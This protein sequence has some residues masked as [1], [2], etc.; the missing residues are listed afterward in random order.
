VGQ[1][2]A[3]CTL[4]EDKQ[5]KDFTKGLDPDFKFGLQALYEYVK[6]SRPNTTYI[7]LSEEDENGQ[8]SK[9]TGIA[10]IRT[11]IT[12]LFNVAESSGKVMSISEKAYFNMIN[13]VIGIGEAP[14]SEFCILEA[15][16]ERDHGTLTIEFFGKA[17]T[18]DFD[19]DE[20]LS[21]SDDSSFG[22]G[23]GY[24]EDGSD[25][26]D[27]QEQSNAEFERLQM[28]YADLGEPE[29][30]VSIVINLFKLD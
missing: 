19:Y 1:L 7:S 29:H 14:E 18:D 6:D 2:S 25:D 8:T 15:T 5:M 13:M 17:P 11:Y 21:L 28:K 4:K 27:I 10:Y 22:T 12:E 9:E 30:H 20:W 24:E 16:G 26:E 3:A 23:I